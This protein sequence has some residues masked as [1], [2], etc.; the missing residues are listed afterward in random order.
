MKRYKPLGSRL[1]VETINTTLSLEERA[2]NAGLE[3]VVEMENRPRP[4]QGKVLALGPDPLLHE[5]I[6]VGDTVFF[7]PYAGS[8]VTLE[9][10]TYRQLELGEVTGVMQDEVIDSTSSPQ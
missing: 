3:I 4:T 2:K 6:K 8:E 7:M 5:Q 9:G 10:V 1:L